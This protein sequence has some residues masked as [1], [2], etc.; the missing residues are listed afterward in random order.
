MN[1]P[2]NKN[3]VIGAFLGTIVEYYDYSLYGFSAGILA[4]KFFPGA[5]RISSLMYVF[6]IYALSYV[7]KPFGSLFFS[8]FYHCFQNKY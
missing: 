1:K 8:F 2:K 4:T 6:A 7:A 3:K 5:D